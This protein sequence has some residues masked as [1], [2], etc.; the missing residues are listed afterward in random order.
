MFQTN[1]FDHN[2]KIMLTLKFFFVDIAIQRFQNRVSIDQLSG[3]NIYDFS[4]QVDKSLRATE[5]N[6]SKINKFKM[7][8]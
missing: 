7:V 3:T 6:R 2:L 1:I 5:M 4:I 8:C